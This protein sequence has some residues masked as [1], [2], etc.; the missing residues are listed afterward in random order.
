MR[1]YQNPQRKAGTSPAFSLSL[2]SCFSSGRAVYQ[3]NVSH[4]GVVASTETAF[5]NAS[6]TAGALQ[7]ART[8]FIEQLSH[9]RVIASTG[10]C[11]ATI[12]NAISLGKG[13]QRFNYTTQLFALGRVVLMIS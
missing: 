3:L 13:D 4:R 2:S 8:Q 9:D 11:Q 5:Q 12:S 10:K 6:I 7:V 1:Q